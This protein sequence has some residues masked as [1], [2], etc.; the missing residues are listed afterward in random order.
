MSDLEFS[1]P[2]LGDRDAIRDAFRAHP[3]MLA[4]AAGPAPEGGDQ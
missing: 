1:V 4:I 3:A 2:P